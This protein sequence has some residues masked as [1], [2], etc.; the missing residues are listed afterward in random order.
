MNI[1]ITEIGLRQVKRILDD[2]KLTSHLIEKSDKMPISSIILNFN[3]SDNSNID[4]AIA[5]IPLPENLFPDVKILQ[6]FY[7]FPEIVVNSNENLSLEL[8]NRINYLLPIG[9]FGIKDKK[10]TYRYCHVMPIFSNL[11][12]QKDSIKDL[13]KI[14]ALYTETFL[15]PI[16]NVMNG[17]LGID[18]MFKMFE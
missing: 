7:E 10:I 1:E 12:D 2:L 14:I 16:N 17:T 8:T 11:L 3:S 15:E 18:E 13:I 6:F 4:I 9:S 5:F